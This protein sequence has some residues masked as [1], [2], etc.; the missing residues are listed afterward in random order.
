MTI[1]MKQI[2]F[3]NFR[4][5]EYFPPLQFGDITYLVGGNNCG[6]STL[7]KAL[8]LTF[9]NLRHIR[10]SW[11]DSSSHAPKFRFDAN[12]IHDLHVGTFWRALNHQAN[13]KK[14]K[15]I[16][17]S[18]M[19]EQLTFGITI[20]GNEN[21][22]DDSYETLSPIT[23]L[24]IDDPEGIAVSFDYKNSQATLLSHGSK[25]TFKMERPTVSMN[26]NDIINQIVDFSDTCEQY[27][28]EIRLLAK[29]VAAA[30]RNNVIEYIYTHAVAQ[31][32]VFSYE[33]KNDYIAAVLHDYFEEQIQENDKERLFVLEWMKKFEIGTDFQIDCKSGAA[34]YVKVKNMTNR[35]MELA[36]LGLGYI[37][38]M[39]LLLKLATFISRYEGPA[40]PTPT[41]VIEEPEQNLHPRLQ[42][43]LADLFADIYTDYGFRFIIETHSEYIIRSVQNIVLQQSYHDQDE[44]EQKNPFKVYYFPIDKAPYDMGF[45][46]SGRFKN[47]FESGF[48]DEAGRLHMTIIKH[49]R[50][51]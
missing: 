13:D 12:Q 15:T 28:E 8:L 24:S 9:D 17:F 25:L 47:K 7:V 42:S 2:S 37:Q 51:K 49:E 36:D 11:K 45:M 50:R 32:I 44:L 23:I 38:I 18:L 21:D 3:S 31:K 10:N 1:N 14:D 34:Y 26:E 22:K 29:K 19:V 27:R 35:E 39:I 6:K 30:L 5:F 4:R 43:L 46:P 20:E 41:I 16:S 40:T 33:D 48:F